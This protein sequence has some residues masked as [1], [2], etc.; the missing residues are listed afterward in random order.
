MAAYET[1]WLRIETRCQCAVVSDVE[2]GLICLLR[3]RRNNSVCWQS[4]QV[5]APPGS[6]FFCRLYTPVCSVG[7]DDD[8]LLGEQMDTWIEHWYNNNENA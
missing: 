7:Q 1:K 4:L 6:T 2:L 3:C 8:N 5:V